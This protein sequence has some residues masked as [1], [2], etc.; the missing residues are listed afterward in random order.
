MVF[1]QD[2]IKIQLLKRKHAVLYTYS[3]FWELVPA[4]GGAYKSILSLYGNSHQK[5]KSNI[6]EVF[7]LFLSELIQ[8]I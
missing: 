2:Q 8:A 7:S 4:V 1:K 3:F 5:V 6:V